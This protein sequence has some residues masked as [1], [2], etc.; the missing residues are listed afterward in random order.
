MADWTLKRR[1]GTKKSKR[2]EKVW[3][4]GHRSGE[5][6][7]RSPKGKMLRDRL[8]IEAERRQEKVQKGRCCVEN[9][10]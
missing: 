3:Q 6:A 10:T 4:I 2:E 9:W 7:R 1:E 8:D 5:K